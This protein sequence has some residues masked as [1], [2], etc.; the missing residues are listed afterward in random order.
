MPGKKRREE[1]D[2]R[3]ERCESE[4]RMSN[5]QDP[6]QRKKVYYC[7]N[8]QRMFEER[9]RYCPRCDTKTMFEIRERL[10]K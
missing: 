4:V 10:K 7:G 6:Q 2:I 9:S 8:C 1:D 3:S 5:L